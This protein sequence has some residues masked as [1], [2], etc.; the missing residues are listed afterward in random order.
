M[1]LK[2]QGRKQTINTRE[3]SVLFGGGDGPTSERKG[4]VGKGVRSVRV[5]VGG[6]VS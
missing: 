6:S 4:R 3:L 5:G 2:L 1:E